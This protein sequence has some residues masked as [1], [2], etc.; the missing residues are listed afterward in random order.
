VILL[1]ASF[2]TL[3]F[4]VDAADEEICCAITER[5]RDSK[6]E[7]TDCSWGFKLQTSLFSMTFFKWGQVDFTCAIP[8][9]RC[10]E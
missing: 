2:L 5:T 6:Y 1:L 9:L 3:W 4:I 8:F 10:V 7:L